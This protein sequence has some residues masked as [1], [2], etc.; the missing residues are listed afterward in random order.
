MVYACPS[1]STKG[2]LLEPFLLIRRFNTESSQDIHHINFT[3]DSRFFIYSSD[4]FVLRT[5]GTLGG[6]FPRAKL[7]GHKARILGT[8]S[9]L[10]INSCLLSIDKAGVVLLWEMVPDDQPQN[11]KFKS[12][13]GNKIKK[14]EEEGDIEETVQSLACLSEL[15]SKFMKCRFT[16]KHKLLLFQEKTTIDQIGVSEDKEHLTVAFKNQSFGVYR[17]NPFDPENL[18]QNLITFRKE[19]SFGEV[20]SLVMHPAKP[21]I[22]FGDSKK[23][24]VVWDWKAKNYILKQRALTGSISAIAFSPENKFLA[25]GDAFGLVKVFDFRSLLNTVS[26]EDASGKITG[27]E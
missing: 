24:L 11:S 21:L 17:L 1:P 25:M 7:R 9:F 22:C 4:D 8:V 15:E 13:S 26:F 20:K 3:D 27:I 16:L 18:I 6:K 14:I 12:L 2:R 5:A 23:S 19:S 10:D